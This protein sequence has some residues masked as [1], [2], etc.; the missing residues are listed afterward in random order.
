[1]LQLIEAR[2][3]F[4]KCFS[5]A[6]CSDETGTLETI[7]SLHVLLGLIVLSRTLVSFATLLVSFLASFCMSK[8][9]ETCTGKSCTSLLHLI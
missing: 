2:T 6:C 1:M 3:A 5:Y 7:G 8:V 4:P 9:Q